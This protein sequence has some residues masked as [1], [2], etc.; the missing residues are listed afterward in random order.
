[1]IRTL[2]ITAALLCLL[3]A[4]TALGH[5]VIVGAWLEGDE[6]VV[7]VG[8]GDG[9]MAEGARVSVLDK[10]SGEVLLEGQVDAEGV[11][12]TVVPAEILARGRDLQ[13]VA[14]AGSGHRAE[15]IIEA[16]EFPD[17]VAVADTAQSPARTDGPPNRE[18]AD[19]TSLDEAAL[20]ALIRKAVQD[21]VRPLRRKIEA[22]SDSKPG[23]TEIIGGIGYLFGLA[24]L[25]ALLKRPGRKG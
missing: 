14:D 25:V 1:M 11:Y 9:S 3:G 20:E 15:T 12:T 7:E 8:F 4:S 10:V 17:T 18:L 22:L 6:V 24:G 19:G 16:A 2:C 21:E 5:K 13:V 23:P